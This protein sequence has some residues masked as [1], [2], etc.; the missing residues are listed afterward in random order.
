MEQFA[1][2]LNITYNDLLQTETY[3]YANGISNIIYNHYIKEVPIEKRAFHCLDIPRKIF[4]YHLEKIGWTRD[5]RQLEHII[6]LVHNLLS[7][8]INDFKIEEF[9]KID[10]FNLEDKS[11]QLY[12]EKIAKFDSLMPSKCITEEQ[13][14]F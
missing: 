6:K 1:S 3:G 7:K 5:N 12:N 9:K 13:K 11:V 14:N 8:R 4:I 2:N 10:K